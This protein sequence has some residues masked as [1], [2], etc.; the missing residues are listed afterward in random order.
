[1]CT[2]IGSPKC[3]S[4]QN[5]P[6]FNIFL[7]T[8]S[9]FPVISETNSRFFQIFLAT[10]R[11]FAENLARILAGVKGFG[12]PPHPGG[13]S[14]CVSLPAVGRFRPS[15][16]LWGLLPSL[17]AAC[18]PAKNRPSVGLELGFV[19]PSLWPFPWGFYYIACLRTLSSGEQ[20]A[21]IFIPFARPFACPLQSLCTSFVK[22]VTGE[23]F[24]II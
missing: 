3:S 4:A 17:P 5:T 7:H 12:L 23:A 21:K 16:L 20:R 9:V 22:T 13:G 10:G 19:R 15:V 18:P 2:T 11:L 6:F 14:L 24:A 8:K 1:M